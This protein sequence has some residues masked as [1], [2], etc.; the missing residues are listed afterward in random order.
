MFVFLQQSLTDFILELDML[1]NLRCNLKMFTKFHSNFIIVCIMNVSN[2]WKYIATVF[3]L[4]QSI[5]LIFSRKNW[6]WNVVWNQLSII[7]YSTRFVQNLSF[8][9]TYYLSHE[10]VAHTKFICICIF[11]KA[12]YIKGGY[13]WN[14]WIC[15]G[16]RIHI[17][18]I[19]FYI[20]L[21]GEN[22]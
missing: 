22:V 21:N 10:V 12:D 16:F 6:L 11:F 13:L 20:I 4:H 17:N 5:G 2:K 3:E 1:F 7:N 15:C 14:K 9:S 19:H 8:P 18:Y